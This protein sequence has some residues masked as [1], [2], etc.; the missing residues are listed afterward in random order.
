MTNAFYTATG[1]PGRRADG[2]SVLMRGEF[3]L[4]QTAFDHMPQITTTGQFNTIFNQSGNFT[5][6]LPPGPGTLALISDVT[7]AVSVVSTAGGATAVAL[8]AE[9][10]RA[11]AAEAANATAVTT[12]AS[13]RISGDAAEL[14]ARNVAIGVETARATAAENIIATSVTTE[15]AVRSAAISAET[16]RATAAEL[17]LLGFG[18]LFGMSMSNDGS[19]PNTVIDISAGSCIDSTAAAIIRITAFKKAI[20]GSWVA[21]TGAN[22]MGQGLTATASTW[23]HVFAVIVSGI[24]DV[25]FDTS[26]TAANKP[27]STTAFRRIGSIKLD[28][29]VH[30]L[31]FSQNGDRF[32]WGTTIQEVNGNIGVTTAVNHTLA[33]CPPGVVT[34]AMLSGYL[35]D[36]T[37][38]SASLYISSLAQSNQVPSTSANTGIA[39]ATNQN[40]SFNLTVETD[41]SQ[42]VRFRAA[43]TTLATSVVTS[44]YLDSRGRN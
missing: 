6:T 40:F 26:V 25:Y 10:A 7:T 1:N 21:G 37:T 30:I 33:G 13:A 20:S 5:F 27:A 44:G 19:S 3:L 29:S 11:L 22:G 38:A 36:T 2:F 18:S 41:T 23:Y 42:Q 31:V 9:T 17:A 15:A 35:N 12:E 28:G 39:A 32:D 4:I 34:Q 16:A 14:A 24:A 43:T 8:T